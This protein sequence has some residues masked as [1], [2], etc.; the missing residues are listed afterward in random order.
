MSIVTLE[1]PASRNRTSHVASHVNASQTA[2]RHESQHDSDRDRDGQTDFRPTPSR[3]RAKAARQAAADQLRAD[4]AAKLEAMILA[5]LELRET[6]QR[7]FGEAGV[8][9]DAVMEALHARGEKSVRLP[10][11]GKTVVVLEEYTD[12]TGM[13][14]IYCDH[15]Q[16]IPAGVIPE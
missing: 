1:G 3:Q 8:I 4:K 15:I 9:E 10:A 14:S 11:S 6:A 7:L 5:W 13:T 12:P 2:N 16:V